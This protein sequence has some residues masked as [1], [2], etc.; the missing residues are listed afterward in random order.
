MVATPRLDGQDTQMSSRSRV[1]PPSEEDDLVYSLHCKISFEDDIY[2]LFL[3]FIH[4]LVAH[5]NA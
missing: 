3:T 1:V 2:Y 4:D 5:K